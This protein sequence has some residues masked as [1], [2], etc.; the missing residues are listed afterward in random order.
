MKVFVYDKRHSKLVK[1]IVDVVAVREDRSKGLI[2]VETK[3]GFDFGY[4]L[5]KYKTTAYQN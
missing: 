5:R 4:D 2:L 3:E 1:T